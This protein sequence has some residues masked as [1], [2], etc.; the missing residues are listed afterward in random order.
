MARAPTYANVDPKASYADPTVR[1]FGYNGHDGVYYSLM[2]I[3]TFFA[4]PLV[5]IL[6]PYS[7]TGEQ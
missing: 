2:K 5:S 6:P 4:G 3:V 7:P 1:A